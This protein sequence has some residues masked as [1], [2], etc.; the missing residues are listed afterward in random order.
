MKA[1]TEQAIVELNETAKEIFVLLKLMQ[2]NTE[3]MQCDLEYIRDD[4]EVMKG[5]I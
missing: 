3:I 2:D 5:R 4:I 1:Q